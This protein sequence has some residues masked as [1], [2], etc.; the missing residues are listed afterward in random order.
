[1]VVDDDEINL[2]ALFGVLFGRKFLI[3]ALT[4]LGMFL[5][6]FGTLSSRNIYSADALVQLEEKTSS[7][8][9]LEAMDVFAEAPRTAAEIEIITSR[10]VIGS[11]VDTL[12]LSLVAEPLA[13]PVLRRLPELLPPVLSRALEEVVPF[14][15]GFNWGDAAISASRL[16]V[17]SEMLNEELFVRKLTPTN[18]EVSL[19][20]GRTLE[21]TL[22]M[23]LRDE[24]SGLVLKVDQLSG[25]IGRMFVLK[26]LR[27]MDAINAVKNGLTVS[28]RGRNT[29]ILSIVYQDVSPERA[30]RILR[31][32]TSAY[33]GQNISR[34]SADIEQSL[35]FV[36]EQLPQ[37]KVR[38][39]EAK[40]ALNEYL[41]SQNAVDL[42]R[43]SEAL[44]TR[45][46]ELEGE[47]SQVLLEEERVSRRYLP[48]H[49][50]YQDL[51]LNQGQLE[52]Q[53]AELEEGIEALPETQKQVFNLRQSVEISQEI[54]RQFLNRSQELGV[55]KASSIGNVRVVDEAVASSI[56]VAPR[57][58]RVLALG[59]LLGFMIGCASA[60][61][62]FFFRKTFDTLSDLEPLGLS[63][64]GVIGQISGLP[65]QRPKR[66]DAITRL[67][68]TDGNEAP[69][70]AFKSIRTSL[71]FSLADKSPKALALTSAQPGDGKSFVSHNIAEAV[72]ASG[73][74]TVL[75][76]TDMR[77]GYLHRTFGVSHTLPGLSEYLAGDIELEQ[78]FQHVGENL[79]LIPRGKVPPNPSELLMSHR[80]AELVKLLD[81]L[82]DVSVYDTPPFLAVTDPLIVF[83]HV[84]IRLA[85]ARHGKTELGAIGA[86]KSICD[87]EDLP[88]DG[89]I[90]NGFDAKRAKGY[91]GYGYGGYGYTGAY[92]YGSNKDER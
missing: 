62:L 13:P 35:L 54:Y 14:S 7:I 3:L 45:L 12:D 41:R 39:D 53:I 1:M 8:P 64:Y 55:A 34:N 59:T 78:A 11:V 56:P 79:V 70:E 19:P 2:G 33:L 5:S 27:R 66:G 31:E 32:V 87:K 38:A 65:T 89:L 83:R 17:P 23:I 21:G 30:Q 6:A 24:T 74:R 60:L 48:D 22:G 52:Q 73:Q 82:F 29:S 16:E 84:P 75:I 86:V 26:R 90:V 36:E 46:T 76:D 9:G 57:T 47:L 85:L 15:G 28:E 69:K 77:R 63:L 61:A 40:E 51:L 20:D 18:F 68:Q 50:I 37:A 72:G 71:H 49:P 4:T 25:R 67:S 88:L 58:S 81:E 43:E 80:F 42:E 92:S 10:L 44:L 91:G